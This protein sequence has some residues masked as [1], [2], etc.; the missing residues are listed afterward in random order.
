MHKAKRW[1]LA[2]IALALL[3]CSC[4]SFGN[5]FKAIPAYD[6]KSYESFTYLKADV[7]MFYDTFTKEFDEDKYTELIV[8]FNR[9]KEYESGKAG[10]E[11]ITSQLAIIRDMFSRHCNEVRVK[12]YSETMLANKKELISMAFDVLIKT[13]Y[14]K[15]K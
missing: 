11:E 3:L 12:P 9:I 6:Q 1:N 4:T 15:K 14:S 5:Y 8:R 7:V 13:E 2:I 10:N